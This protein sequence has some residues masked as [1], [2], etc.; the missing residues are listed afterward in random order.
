M[1]S[2]LQN[3]VA[4]APVPLLRLLTDRLPDNV[5]VPAVVI[6]PPV[7]LSPVVPPD[8]F[9]DV[10]VPDAPDKPLVTCISSLTLVEIY[11]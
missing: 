5:I 2:P 7:K 11:F 4:L 1:P 3:V 9:I 10:T 6:G 8:T